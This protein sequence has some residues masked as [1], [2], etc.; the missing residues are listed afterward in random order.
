MS[1]HPDQKVR[2][3]GGPKPL[4]EYSRDVLLFAPIRRAVICLS[5]TYIYVSIR[6]HTDLTCSSVLPEY[7]PNLVVLLPKRISSLSSG[8]SQFRP[9][10]SLNYW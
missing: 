5:V 1:K 4:S 2:Q 9:E 6:G 3:R 7:L 8:H 10:G